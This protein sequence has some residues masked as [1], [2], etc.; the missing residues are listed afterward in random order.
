[1][2]L[3]VFG[4]GK[5]GLCSAACFAARGHRVWGYDKNPEVMAALRR[6]ENPLREPG[7]DELLVQAWPNF[8]VSEDVPRMVEVSEVS[9]IIVP[10]PSLPD[11]CFSN[12]AVLSVLRDIASGLRHKPD[13]HV[14]NVVS[15]VMPGSCTGEFQPLLEELSGKSCG[16]DFGLVYNPEFIALGSVIHNFLNPDL[17]LIGASDERSGEVVRR[18]YQST[19]QNQPQV[20]VMSL[21][22]AELTKLSLNCF[23][24][25]KISFVNELAALCEKIPGADVDVITAA[26][27]AD[28]RIGP[29]TLKGGLGFGGPCFPRD[30][31][32]FQAAARKAGCQARLSRQ[33][34]EVNRDVVDR[35]YQQVVERLHPPARVALLGLAYKPGT[36][37]VEESQALELAQR[38]A[39]AGYAVKVHDPEALE[40]ARQVLGPRVSYHQEPEE[41]L[42]EVDAVVLATPWPLYSRLEVAKIANGPNGRPVIVD[43]WRLLKK[44]LP[45]DVPYLGLGLGPAAGRR[46][47]AVSRP[48]PE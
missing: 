14:V 48:S 16:R 29:H 18:L 28:R 17:V 25:L 2:R 7:L 33:V 12:A 15:T 23:V 38:L 9:L 20:A 34:V 8:K 45:P 43:C 39:E 6:R 21:I 22:N 42:R 3:S 1:M 44:R 31:L 10:T 27:G 32:A 19:C 37:V 47:K 5:L 46:G 4:L 26:L 41:C 13:F 30:N 11:G 24:T 40:E 35:L 36:P